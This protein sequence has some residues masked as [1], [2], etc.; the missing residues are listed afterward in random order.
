MTDKPYMY[1][2]FMKDKLEGYVMTAEEKRMWDDRFQLGEGIL[3]E[4]NGK[5]WVYID[6][7]GNRAQRRAHRSKQ[8]KAFGREP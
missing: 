7:D 2:Y 4:Y 8:L 3:V 1:E 6:S 5:E